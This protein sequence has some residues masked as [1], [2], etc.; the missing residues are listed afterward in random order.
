MSKFKIIIFLILGVT[1]I[2]GLIV[3]H[4]LV[5]FH[6]ITLNV[7]GEITSIVYKVVDNKDQPP[8]STIKSTILISLQNGQYCVK[9][10]DTKYNTSPICF[11]VQDKDMS[12]TIDPDYSDNYLEQ[13]LTTQIDQI[14]S[15]ITTKYSPIIAS[16][17]LIGGKLYGKGEWYGTTLTEKV[18][19]SDRGDVYRVLLEKKGNSWVIV[20]YP[21]IVLS[22]LDYPQVPFTVLSDVNQLLG[23]Y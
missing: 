9:P 4:Y 6:S 15:V 11:T 3:W 12:I 18:A 2:A 8:L 17:T 21:Q 13:L 5:S 10:A 1:V 20:A 23:V 14:D 16:Y 7:R 19:P 22:K